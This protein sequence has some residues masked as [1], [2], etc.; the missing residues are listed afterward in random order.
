[1]CVSFCRN[2]FLLSSLQRCLQSLKVSKMFHFSRAVLF[3]WLYPKVLHVYSV[4]KN[5]NR[6][7]PGGA[8]FFQYFH[9][10]LFLDKWLCIADTFCAFIPGVAVD[11]SPRSAQQYQG[12]FTNRSRQ[13]RTR[14]GLLN[15]SFRKM[16]FLTRKLRFRPI[17]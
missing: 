6:W 5:L 15:Q 10:H 3:F 2:H 1:M 13:L 14:Y 4:L 7:F 12:P 8:G 17:F 9:W 16:P 11:D